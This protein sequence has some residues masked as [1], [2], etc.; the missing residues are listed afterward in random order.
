M[1]IDGKKIGN[2]TRPL[3]SSYITAMFSPGAGAQLMDIPIEL[4]D[5]WEDEQY[6]KQPFNPYPPDEL[7][8]LA[9]NIKRYGILQPVYVRPRGQRYQILAGHNRVEGAKLA[10]CATAP[11]IARELNDGEAR[12]VMIDTNL[13]QRKKTA[14]SEKAWA[15]R[16]RLET[17]RC[18]GQH[19]TSRQ[20]VGKLEC[21]DLAGITSRQLVGKSEGDNL[22][23]ITSRQL[24]GKSEGNNLSGIT[25]R[26]L[27][28]KSEGD[29]LSGITSRQLVGKSEGNNL[30]GITSR[31]LVGKLEG[32]DLSG[33]TSR[34]VVGKLE[35][36]DVVGEATGDSGRQVQRYIRLTYLIPPLLE[37]VDAEKIPFTAGVSLSYLEEEKQQAVWG[38]MLSH[39]IGRVSRAQAEELRTFA[40]ELDDNLIL[41]IFGILQSPAKGKS[42]TFKVPSDLLPA[43]ASKKLFLDPVFLERFAELVK[44]FAER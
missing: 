37:L 14:P 36:A 39:S 35:S 29:N 44:E 20:L 31:Q 24:V 12:L 23:G 42:V 18:Q 21:D 38:I 2:N 27:V 4:L 11:C 43:N 32:N 7:A 9:Q 13:F 16:M 28:G 40:E 33:I 22:S 34:Q 8:E 1:K 30:S 3:G 25:S 17:I 5:P 6:G 19:S 26:Q 15:Y 41:R 10:G